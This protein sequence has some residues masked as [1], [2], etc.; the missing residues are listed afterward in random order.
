MPVCVYEG[1][2][3]GSKRQDKEQIPGV[4][5]HKFPKHP[6]LRKKWLQQTNKNVQHTYIDKV[7]EYNIRS[8]SGVFNVSPIESKKCC[9]KLFT[10]DNKNVQNELGVE[11]LGDNILDI[12]SNVLIERLQNDLEQCK[13]KNEILL[14]E[15]NKLRTTVK[16]LKDRMNL[17]D[18]RFESRF[19]KLL[20]NLFTSTQI[21]FLL[22]PTKKICRW[23][24]EDISSA[25]TLRS[26]SPKAY[27]YLRNKKGFPL[28][29]LST[30]RS[31]ASKFSVEP[32][33]LH[34][35]LSL[36]KSK[37]DTMETNDKL[38]ILCF[39]ET[40][41]SKRI[42]FDKKNEQVLG[43]HKSVQTVIARG[44]INNWKQPIYYN[45]DERMTKEILNKIIEEL[46]EVGFNVVAIV[47]DSGST[48]VGLWK[49]LDIS[50]NNTSFEHPK[51]NSRIHVFAD[52]PHL[53]K[54]ARNHLLDSGFILPN[55]KFIGKNIL[56]EVLNLNYG[57][58]Y[59]FAHKLSERHLF[60][61]G[62]GRMNVRL[63]A[64]VFS[65]SVSKAIAYCGEKN[66]P[67]KYNWKEVII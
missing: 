2:F 38:T 48:N 54:L 45:F 29:G 22:H 5:V 28:P 21:K 32:G 30:L 62:S 50:I 55:G 25:I 35:V 8:P 31:W 37:G 1:C 9:V 10:G 59:K 47:S 40:Y 19:G 57:K 64:N 63:A 52:V 49:S 26:V 27:R 4:H 23:L 33:L 13:K 51:L 24:P 20:S 34:G 65:N 14:T 36:M 39:D 41:I 17:E 58:D 44:L 7:G 18:N 15:N 53:L 11:P 66:C 56:H 61:E 67:D 6:E 60:V 16:T 46:S 3:S 43:P 42:C 12:S